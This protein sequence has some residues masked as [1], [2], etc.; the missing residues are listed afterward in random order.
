MTG[1]ILI[2]IGSLLIL[3]AVRLALANS[4]KDGE[5]ITPPTFITAQRTEQ[6]WNTGIPAAKEVT[7]SES[8]PAGSF[9]INEAGVIE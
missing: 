3:L 5:E 4:G 9:P 6:D 8:D 1:A 2:I 7:K